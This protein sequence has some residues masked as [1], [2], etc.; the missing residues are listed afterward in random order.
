MFLI[1]ILWVFAKR[2]EV[3]EKERINT[4]AFMSSKYLSI[5]Q[6]RIVAERK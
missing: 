2:T 1:L 4:K 3:M 5:L 6:M